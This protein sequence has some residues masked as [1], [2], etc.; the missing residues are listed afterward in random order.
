MFISRSSLWSNLTCVN[1]D[2]TRVYFKRSGSSPINLQLCRGLGLSSLYAFLQIIPQ[3]ICRLKSLSVSTVAG[4]LQET[5]SYL[6]HPAPLLETLDINSGC[7]N[8]PPY[9][10]VLA[11]TIFNGDLSSLR[12]IHLECV[13]TE[14]PW[15]NMANLTSFTLN[16]SSVGN[17]RRLLDFFESAPHLRKIGLLS[18]TLISGGENG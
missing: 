16:T 6:S 11:S 13:C 8:E 4:D 1:A 9:Y 14:L 18:T 10:P 12:R 3:A 17:F 15:K 5:I 2:K 7:Y